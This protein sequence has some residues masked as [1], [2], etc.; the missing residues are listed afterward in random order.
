MRALFCDSNSFSLSLIAFL[1]YI[2]AFA[3][4]IPI[5]IYTQTCIQIDTASLYQSIHMGT[6]MCITTV[7]LVYLYILFP[8]FSI[9]DWSPRQ[10]EVGTSP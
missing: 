4:C 10:A 5:Y 9:K 3:A 7:N 6:Y 2:G 8:P 1:K